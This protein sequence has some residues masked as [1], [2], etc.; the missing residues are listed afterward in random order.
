MQTN[1]NSSLRV[2]L[3]CQRVLRAS[4]MSPPEDETFASPHGNL[5]KDNAQMNQFKRLVISLMN[6]YR[7]IKSNYLSFCKL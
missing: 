2:L 6:L 1:T 7:N 5:L 4:R 3:T